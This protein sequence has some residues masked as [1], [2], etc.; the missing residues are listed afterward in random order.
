MIDT[1]VSNGGFVGDGDD[2]GVFVGVA[3]RVGDAQG[4]GVF[5]RIKGLLQRNA[6]AQGRSVFEPLVADDI[7]GRSDIG[8]GRTIE[9][10]IQTRKQGLIRTGIGDR[11]GVGDGDEHGVAVYVACRVSHG[12]GDG[13]CANR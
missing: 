7:A 1:C 10:D 2:D 11:W 5:T 8:R 6:S 9:R 3:C 12:E 4:D 13:V